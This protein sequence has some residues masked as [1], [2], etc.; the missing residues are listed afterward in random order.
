MGKY[1]KLHVQILAMRL[2]SC[3][4]SDHLC[5]SRPHVQREGAASAGARCLQLYESAGFT[6]QKAGGEKLRFQE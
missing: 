1:G 4:T 2:L 5:F 3:L 6:R